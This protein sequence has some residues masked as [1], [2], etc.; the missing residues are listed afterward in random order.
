MPTAIV[1]QLNGRIVHVRLVSS[2]SSDTTTPGEA[3]EAGAPMAAAEGEA[4]TE[5]KGPSPIAP[6]GKELIW[7]GGSFVVLLVLM[8]LVL[9]PKVKKGI[10]TRYG[11]IR[12]NI[13]GATNVRA[14]ARAEV[15]AYESA[16]VD[17]RAE[18]SRRVDEARR[19]LDAERQVA[20]T[21]V[22]AR[23]AERKAEVDAANAAV[24]AAASADVSVAIAS[25]ATT[26]TQ[27]AVG[28]AP[29]AAVVSRAVEE[30]LQLSG[31]QR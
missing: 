12:A 27:I 23:I 15:A 21:A 26:A 30:S 2:G 3:L 9:F 25:V 16:L 11:N 31:G 13:D 20:I 22:T 7:G 17:V 29:D 6:E 14:D 18:A 1:T 24:R 8:R 28:R 19:T 10:E 5:D 4:L